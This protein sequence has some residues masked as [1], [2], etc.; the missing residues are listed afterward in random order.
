MW[1]KSSNFAPDFEK[2]RIQTDEEKD[3]DANDPHFFISDG[4]D[5]RETRMSST[6]SFVMDDVYYCILSFDTSM[7]TD[8]MMDMAEEIINAR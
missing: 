5:E 7:S 4:S 1:G 3:R 6:V 2:D 8:E